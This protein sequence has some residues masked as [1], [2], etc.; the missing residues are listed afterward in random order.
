MPTAK[1]PF[2]QPSNG[3]DK[4]TLKS[5]VTPG[6]REV[7]ERIVVRPARTIGLRPGQRVVARRSDR[8][9]VETQ[10]NLDAWTWIIPE[11]VELF[12]DREPAAE[13]GGRRVSFILHHHP[14]GLRPGM[15][16]EIGA[17]EQAVLRPVVKV[18]VALCT[19]R[20]PFPP[21]TKSR[22]APFWSGSNGSS[23]LVKAKKRMS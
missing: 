20:N 19:P 15:L 14:G 6:F 9:G 7:A 4:L 3:A 1:S 16:L 12:V 22:I 11:G 18:S 23:P 2:G 13:A 10:E 8:R 21:A 5:R 17:D